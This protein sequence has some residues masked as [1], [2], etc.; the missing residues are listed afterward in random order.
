[1]DFSPTDLSSRFVVG[2]I[3]A[4]FHP[5]RSPHAMGDAGRLPAHAL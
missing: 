4:C 2:E 3:H 1:M 5:I